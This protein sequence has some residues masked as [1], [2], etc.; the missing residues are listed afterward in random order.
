MMHDGKSTHAEEKGHA[1]YANHLCDLEPYPS[2]Q[3]LPTLVGLALACALGRCPLALG[4]AVL[5]HP[6][7]LAQPSVV[8][9]LRGLPASAA[10]PPTAAHGANDPT[11][12]NW[13]EADTRTHTSSRRT[14]MTTNM[15]RGTQSRAARPLAGYRGTALGSILPGASAVPFA[16]GRAS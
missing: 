13:D 16:T 11:G 2:P 14:N 3:F 12:D 1:A 15:T 7:S 10:S 6:A 4:S 8:P 9:R 5:R